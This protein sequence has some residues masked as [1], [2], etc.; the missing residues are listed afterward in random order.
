MEEMRGKVKKVLIFGL[1]SLYAGVEALI[2]NYVNHLDENEYAVDLVVTERKPEYLDDKL[3]RNVD[4]RI[5]P[6]RVRNYVAYGKSMDKIVKTGGYDII[7]ANF[8]TLTDI[9]VLKSAQKYDVPIRIAHSHNSENMGSF[10]VM[11]THLMNK[12]KIIQYANKFYA[13][14]DFAGEFMF[15]REIVESKDYKIIPNAIEASKYRF[16]PEIREQI[17]EK[18]QLSNKIVVGHVGRFHFQKNHTQLIKIYKKFLEK[19]SNSILLL[20]GTG[21]LMD[22]IKQLVHREGIEGN[23]LFLGNR[24]DVNDLMQAMDVLLFPSLFEGLPV[25]L[26]EAQAAGL[27][28]VISDKITKQAQITDLIKYESLDAPLENWVD[29]IEQSLLIKRSD[30]LGTIQN[31][32]YDVCECATWLF[33]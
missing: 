10:L 30:Y 32:G 13:C 4:I 25:T 21:N 14:S 9:Q 27:P 26:I 23:V 8:C 28:C 33:D 18:M 6:N 17:R 15:G 31:A 24:S 2:L 3:L 22:E 1:S 29:D 5:V 19:K 11:A 7:W 20:V 12:K 16:T